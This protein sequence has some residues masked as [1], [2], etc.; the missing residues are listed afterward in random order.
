MTYATVQP[1]DN[2]IGNETYGVFFAGGAGNGAY[3]YDFNT[4]S[5]LQIGTII[6]QGGP[7][8]NYSASFIWSY[9]NMTTVRDY[10]FTIII[11]KSAFGNTTSLQAEGLAASEETP[12]D[13]L[14]EKVVAACGLLSTTNEKVHIDKWLEALDMANMY[15][16]SAAAGS[17]E[18][19][20]VMGAIGEVIVGNKEGL[21]EGEAGNIYKR[22]PGSAIFS[23]LFTTLDILCT[24]IQLASCHVKAPGCQAACQE[25][26]METILFSED[27]C[28]NKC[29]MIYP[30]P[31]CP[32]YPPFG[33]FFCEALSPSAC[34]IGCGVCGFNEY[35]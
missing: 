3:A 33:R 11:P 2:T 4:G 23:I 19:G 28:I 31:C 20:V 12:C 34:N 15:F 16:V 24:P 7:T 14:L 25:A 27:V 18:E 35:P 30:D 8:G 22:I 13:P 21:E 1:V 6:S 9:R 32:V 17:E 29:I 26:P 5:R 10:N